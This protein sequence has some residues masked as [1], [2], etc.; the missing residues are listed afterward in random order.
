MAWVLALLCAG[1]SAQAGAARNLFANPNF[2]LGG[3]AP[4]R[5]DK[6]GKTAARFAVVA[7]GAFEG[8]RC[9]LVAIDRVEEWGTQFGQAV[10]PGGKGKTYTFAVMA[11]AVKAPVTVD[12]QI[13]RRGKPY[14]R[15]ARSG[16]F[17]LEPGKWSELHVTF[18]VEKDFPQ[19]WFAYISCTQPN[20]Q[21][22]AD[23]FRLY[24]GDYVP[25]EQVAREEAEV[26]AVR[27]FDT[28][29]TSAV[30]LP[31]EAV[32]KRKGWTALAEDDTRHRFRGDA[33]LVNN[34]LAVVLRRKG[35]G[36]EVYALRRD[37][38]AL[39]AVL[40]PVG[41][42]R[43]ASLASLKIAANDPSGVAVDAAF[44]ATD[45]KG[46]AARFTLSMGQAFVATEPRAGATGLRV[47]A[48]CRF[49]VLP[50]FFA[51]DIVVDAAE[52][53]VPTAELP[54]E[55]FLLHLLGDGDAMAMA[56]WRSREQDVRITLS[57][58]GDARRIDGSEMRF[59]KDKAIWLAVLDGPAAWHA[60]DVA[61]ED[62]GKIVRL[63]WKPPYP[64]QWRVDWRHDN[65]LTDSWE[66][67]VERRDGKF[68]RQGWFGGATTL[69]AD[70]KRWTTVLGRFHYPCFI[71]RKGHAHLQPLK[72]KV[73]RF[74]GPA[75]IYPINRVHATPLDTFTVVDIVR[76]TLGVGPC[77]YILDVE[78]HKTAYKGRATCA[79]RD[80]LRPIYKNKLQK[81]K[82]AAVEKAL[83]DVIVFIKHI[84]G[85]IEAYQAF[86]RDM[87]AYLAEQRKAHPELTAAI[88]DLEALT[89]NIHKRYARR[90]GNIE[91]PADAE[92]LADEFRDT[93]LEAE[94][95][96][97]TKRCF[98]ITAAWVKIG[99]NQDELVGECRMAVKVLRQRAALAMALDPRMAD[100]AT[101][102]RNRTHKILRNPLSYEAPRH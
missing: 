100:I 86:G 94:G 3:S 98:D 23:A 13:E 62:A 60:H 33:V 50:D 57:G 95:D 30:P 37:G 58:E 24:E 96:A 81:P 43:A 75:V 55:N 52:L 78:S 49:A 11:K 101:E 72:S 80:T 8:Q 79:V 90:R 17:A 19:G 41:S 66:M 5:M 91:T 22:R 39:R 102:I 69:P 74:V 73:V 6:G 18:K 56:V 7:D 88:S 92:K 99:G 65:R 82:R 28:G 38:S 84:R 10:E 25:Y 76:A 29:T 20:A 27:L 35:R 85:R 45:G 63:D 26:M 67:A 9:A 97:A 54:S 31:G 46:L 48:P 61:K 44:K 1:A 59:G 89:A 36:A 53:P 83:V 47:E 12:L 34:R 68:E 14:D 42:A 15:A 4:W 32:A 51:D 87:L 64:A 71:D 16:K 77:E 21:Y 70:R 2:E 40:V 93:L